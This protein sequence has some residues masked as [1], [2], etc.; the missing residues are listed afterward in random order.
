MAPQTQQV[1]GRNLNPLVVKHGGRG[2]VHIGT[3]QAG[4]LKRQGLIILPAGFCD[5]G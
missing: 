1:T 2:E 3:E 4:R 5:G